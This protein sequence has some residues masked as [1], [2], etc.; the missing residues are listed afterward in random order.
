MVNSL[1]LELD[2]LDQLPPAEP[3]TISSMCTVFAESE[4]ISLLAA[5]TAKE[6]IVA[7]LYRSIAKRIS[8]MAGSMTVAGNVTFTGGV[9]QSKLLK[10]MLAKE[11]GV[12]VSVPPNP[13]L[14]GALGA[15]IIARQMV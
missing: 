3:V 5:G 13:Q 9:A 10:E 4:V 14:I 1:G 2:Q 8:T 15:A 6:S 12:E 11:L 7:G